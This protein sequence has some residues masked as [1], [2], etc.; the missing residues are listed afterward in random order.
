MT[1]PRPFVLLLCSALF[2][3]SV[4]TAC[5]SPATVG[6]IASAVAAPE[7]ILLVGHAGDLWIVEGGKQR[8]FT[9][10]G[11]WSQPRWSPDGTRLVY[12]YRGENFSDVFVMNR[13]GSESIQLTDS[14]SYILQDS[15][16]IL[17]PT[18]SP[19]QQQIAYISDHASYNPM[20]WVMNA[21]GSGKQ[22]VVSTSYGLEAIE[23]PA[24]SPD[25]A[26]LVFTGFKSGMSQIYRFSVI[27]LELTQITLT[28]G[29]ALDPSWSPDG[30]RIAYV[31]READ[32]TSIHVIGADARGD[33]KIAQASD[34]RTPVW[35]PDGGTL[36]FLSAASGSFEIFMVAVNTTV[37]PIAGSDE[38]QVTTGLDADATSGLTWT[39]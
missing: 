36:A 28:S 2:A 13:D 1:P 5:A 15:D 11:T 24:W 20:L 34:V 26:T 37:D 35:S 29:G 31:A 4:L 8:Q 27:D 22:Q 9:S 21:D 25:G 32:E 3:I 39:R 12:V 23:S 6:S 38:R 16:W 7:G 33:V 18:W 19:D 30:S 10:G 17:S 14:Q